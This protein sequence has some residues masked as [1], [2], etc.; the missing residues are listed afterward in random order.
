MELRVLQYFLTI[1]REMTI[2]GAAERLH[3]SQP[4]LS[5]QIKELEEEVGKQLFVRGN[6]SITLTEEGLLLKK[7][8]EEIINLVEKTQAELAVSDHII[9]G[10]I[11][12]GAG[13][14]EGMRIIA[15]V[16]G[17]IQEK[18][19]GVRFHIFSG[20]ADDVMD[21]LDNGLVDFGIL[22]EPVD[23]TK[24]DFLRLPIKSK[25]G[26]LMRKD[27]ELAINDSITPDVL[28]T[29]PLMCSSQ[30]LVKNEFAGWLGGNN[31][32]LNVISTYNLLY[33][34]SLIV[35][36]TKCYALCLDCIINTSGNSLLCFRPLEPQLEVGVCV[37][38]KK[39][40]LFSKASDEFLRMIQEEIKRYA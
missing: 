9:E 29:I 10:D 20:N 17:K 19:Q 22:I 39:Y 32:K 35:E 16:I 30:Q 12:I 31:R 28:R 36:E 6:R 11:Y 33:N 14:S 37:V 8:A 25:W 26:V 4:T 2:S 13:E 21:K 3:I 27:S 23:M 34:A 1:A 18:Y 15:N 38:W 40:K 5:R 7:R 24:Y